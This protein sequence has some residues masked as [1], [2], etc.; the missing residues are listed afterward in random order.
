V[1]SGYGKELILFGIERGY[2]PY[3]LE[4]IQQVWLGNSPVT[5]ALPRIIEGF[6]IAE[7]HLGNDW[8]EDQRDRPGHALSGAMAVLPVFSMGVRLLAVEQA[9]G[10]SRLLARLRLGDRAAI[11]ELAAAHLAVR[12]LNDVQV[13]FETPV[14]V[15]DR[16]KVPDFCLSKDNCSVFVE[17]TA[18]DRSDAAKM[19]QVFLGKVLFRFENHPKP[20]SAHVLLLREPSDEDIDTIVSVISRL[21]VEI[22][23]C[24]EEIPEIAIVGTN[25]T[26]PGLIEVID[27]GR[28]FGPLL[29]QASWTSE[30]GIPTK[31]I[32]V[33]IPYSD[34]RAAQILK[35]EALQLPPDHPNLVIIDISSVPGA[36]STWEPLILRRLQPKIN[37]RIS[38]VCLVRWETLLKEIGFALV[39]E[40]R[41]VVNP[42]ASKPLPLWL[43]AQLNCAS[44]QEIM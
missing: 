1:G 15:G 6:N 17:V 36:L 35:T 41:L 10:F 13:Q 40:V 9:A 26:P 44:N 33:R 20:L 14:Q 43:S 3:S 27:Y 24:F 32:A 34:T 38:T 30:N 21:S 29:C 42:H 2:M 31:S 37:T 25:H 23:A 7:R 12:G 4:V 39:P 19:A 22:N 8:V 18:P 11:S 5:V 16:V 28:D